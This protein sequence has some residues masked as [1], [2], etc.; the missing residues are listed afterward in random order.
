MPSSGMKDDA[1]LVGSGSLVLSD[2]Q[3][4]ISLDVSREG[5]SSVPMLVAS[6]VVK[7]TS[8][9][10]EPVYYRVRVNTITFPE[11][12]SWKNLACENV[13]PPQSTLTSIL[14]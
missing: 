6:A 3:R 11:S 9:L 14:N 5:G 10:C 12:G 4:M 13:P 1:W 8:G 2:R 7:S